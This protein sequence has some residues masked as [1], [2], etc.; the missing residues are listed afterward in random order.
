MLELNMLRLINGIRIWFRSRDGGAGTRARRVLRPALAAFLAAAALA[1]GCRAAGEPDIDRIVIGLYDSRTDASLRRSRVHRLAEMPLNH[2][3]LVLQ[4]HDVRD[5]LPSDEAMRDVRGIVTWFGAVAFPEPNAYLTWLEAQLRDGK[6]LVIL[7]HPGVDPGRLTALVTRKKFDAV[8]AQLGLRWEGEW[9]EL[10]YS[11]RVVAKNIFMVEFERPLPPALPPY[12]RIGLIGS[13]ARAHLTV[14]REDDGEETPLVV[15]GPNGGYVSPG[16]AALEL[17]RDPDNWAWQINPFR[18]FREALATDEL[19]KLDTTT[20]SGRRVYYS[21]VDGDGWHN[22][23]SALKYAGKNMEAA[24]VLYQDVLL[25]APDMPV[26]IAPISGDLDKTWYG[27]DK[28]R[29]LARQIFALPHVEA[30]SHTHSHPF[31][32]G[33]FRDPN[34][35]KELRYLPLYPA[36]PGHSQADSV[37]DGDKVLAG[38]P[39]PA[40]PPDDAL[41]PGY[42]TPRSYAVQPF[43]LETEVAGS[44]KLIEEVLPPGKH[45]AV[46]QWSGDTSPFERALAL[47]SAAGIRNINGGDSRMDGNFASYAQVAPLG[48]RV[49]AARQVYSSASNENTYTDNWRRR[50]YGYRGLAETLART[51]TP[52]RVKPINIYYHFYSAEREDGLSALWFNLDYARRQEIAPVATSRFV[53]MVDGFNSAHIIVLGE[54][55]WRIEDRDGLETVRFDH[56]SLLAVD[57]ARSEGVIGQRHLQGSLYV[58]LDRAVAAP[59]VA[60]RAYDAPHRDPDAAA[61][62]LVHGRWRV[63][64][65]A[66]Q[67][68]GWQFRGE[69]FGDAEF[70][71]KVPRPGR[72]AIAAVDP[73]GRRAAA[74]AVAGADGLLRFSLAIAGD[75]GAQFTVMRA[76]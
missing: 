39:P 40:M 18:F 71:W 43:R 3:G 42:T 68:R 12:Q 48:V 22:V 34:P 70:V 47:V 8:M 72:Y 9:V 30:G 41:P 53:A 64:G 75:R 15:T 10:T 37:W 36:R 29:D 67:E 17:P 62:Y 58:A 23:S 1:P 5:G 66:Y 76:D 2:L 11:T 26:T 6:K 35:R 16:Y 49:G 60:L 21:Q 65:L 69:G 51:E 46:F 28:T 20:M 44:I 7:G 73:E 14:R 74:E 61:P 52:I 57:F 56:A 54:R 25:R 45:V 59:V 32:W 55:R 19:P 38:Q 4:P 13:A 24:E 33:F 31:T 27:D 50:F 63:E